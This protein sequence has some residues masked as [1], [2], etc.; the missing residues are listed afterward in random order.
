MKTQTYAKLV[1][2][3]LITTCAP[4]D[5]PDMIEMIVADG[6]KPYDEDAGKPD[7]GPLQTLTPVYFE[8]ADRISLY[9]EIVDNAPEIVSAEI[10]RLEQ[11]LAATDYQVVKSF[12]YS[13]AGEELPY[14]IAAVHAER[15]AIRSEIRTLEAQLPA[16]TL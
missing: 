9:W 7:V 14:D 5:E 16:D 4:D 13:L 11:Q 2:G 10:T 6:F 15:E 12:E 1:D 8:E 3:Q